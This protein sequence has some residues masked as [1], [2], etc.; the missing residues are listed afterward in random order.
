MTVSNETVFTPEDL[1]AVEE[2]RKRYPTAQAALMGVL[3][4]YTRRF[5]PITEKA[6]R[7][8]AE[9]LGLTPEDVL[10][11]VTFY[12]MYHRPP[13]RW[14]ILVC[15]NVSCRLC[16]AGMVLE[17]LRDVLGIGPGETTP[18]GLFAVQEAECLGSCGTAPMLSVNEEYHERLT[19]DAIRALI[20]RLKPA[21][22]PDAWGGGSR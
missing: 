1:A 11:V 4:L 5:G 7:H 22:P 18:D 16:G 3:H 21:S 13:A 2:I 9:L 12:E 15:T 19:P 14:N 20:E 8:V 6:I 10:S 17:T